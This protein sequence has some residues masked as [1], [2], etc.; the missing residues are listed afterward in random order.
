LTST[1]RIAGFRPEFLWELDI[2]TRQTMALA[3]AFPA[4]NYLWRPDELARSVSE[5]FLHV[6][7][8]IFMLLDAIGIAAPADLFSGIGEAGGR[9]RLTALIRKSDELMANTREKPVVV[10]LLRRSFQALQESIT[11]ASDAELNR[12]L[13]FFGEETTVRRVYLRMLVHTH[14]HMGQL[15]AYL[16]MNGIRT[17]WPDWR[18][19][20]RARS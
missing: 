14:Q 20:R 5:V 11:E 2:V 1:T 16:R 19:D 3:E 12:S 17:P 18:P 7:T 4:E 10:S 8:G 6:A 15:I 9:E 13:H